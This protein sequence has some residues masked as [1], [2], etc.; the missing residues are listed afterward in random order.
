MSACGQVRFAVPVAEAAVGASGIKEILAM[1]KDNPFMNNDNPFDGKPVA[2]RPV[3]MNA[4]MAEVAQSIIKQVNPSIQ[5]AAEAAT[6]QAVSQVQSSVGMQSRH[7]IDGAYDDIKAKLIEEFGLVPEPIT[8]KTAD[9]VRN[10][11]SAL[12]HERF[13]EVLGIINNDMPVYLYGP[14]G[15]GKSL[16]AKQVAEGLGLDFYVMNSVTDEYKLTGFID[17]NGH[18][19]S[20]QF[21]EAFEKGG[22]FL[23]D[24]IDASAP[25][26]LI[27]INMAIS[28]GW[29][30]FP[31]RRVD[32]HPDFRVIA[33]GN[34]T[35]RG[36][37]SSYRGRTQLDAASLDR[38]VM[39]P[40]D[41]DERI[42][43]Q[44]A[45]KR[46]GDLFEFVKAYRRAITASG[47]ANATCS[48]RRVGQMATL[49]G[50][51]DV[52]TV[53]KSCLLTGLGNDDI[54][55]LRR[56]MEN[57]SSMNL[58]DNRWAKA[59]YAIAS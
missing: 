50:F 54:R 28:N 55:A 57:D 25:D 18:Y 16:L 14:T 8:V 13:N 23:L 45:G 32:A 42:D 10:V 17:A 7:I 38:F 2:G 20:T 36:A 24:E 58:Q 48:H 11:R 9:G 43:R 3:D 21:R 30:A 1:S 5:Q 22:L 33:T 39:I 40:V 4:M 6:R 52:M 15:S 35:G 59:L 27:T 26:V 47:I 44:M 49:I 46:N 56:A 34:T 31:D 53:L 37:D 29:F 41:Y 19:Q 51:M 12:V